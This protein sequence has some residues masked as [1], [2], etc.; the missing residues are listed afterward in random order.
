MRRGKRD[1]LRDKRGADREGKE[2]RV[3]TSRKKR[4]G[5]EKAWLADCLAVKLTHWKRLGKIFLD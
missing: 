4:E 5:G 3:G 1:C 2:K